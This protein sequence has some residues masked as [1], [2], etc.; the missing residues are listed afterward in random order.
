[1]QQ[2]LAFSQ[3]TSSAVILTLVSIKVFFKDFTVKCRKPHTLV[4]RMFIR[5][6]SGSLRRSL[7][8]WEIGSAPSL[9]FL[10]DVEQ[11]SVGVFFFFEVLVHATQGRGQNTIKVIHILMV[12]AP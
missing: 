2:F 3:A 8:F 4:L 1:M 7:K 10:K 11:P 9:G 6:R 5:L 12:L